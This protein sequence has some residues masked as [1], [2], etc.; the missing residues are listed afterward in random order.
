MIVTPLKIFINQME[1]FIIEL[2][3]TYDDS[4]FKMMKESFTLVKKINPRKI[5]DNFILYCYPYKDYIFNKNSDFFMNMNYD[6]E[7]KKYGNKKKE[8]I[9]WWTDI[10]KSYRELWRNDIS[11]KSKD[12]IW[13]YLQVLIKLSEKAIK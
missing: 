5:I 3:E 10:F 11:E 2:N 12:A 6:N 1:N 4:N 9:D 7:T 8:D 13:Q